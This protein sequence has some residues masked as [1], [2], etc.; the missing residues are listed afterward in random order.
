LRER[1]WTEREEDAKEKNKE[2]TENNQK[3][4]V[5]RRPRKSQ[6]AFLKEEKKATVGLK[7]IQEPLPKREVPKTLSCKKERRFRQ[8]TIPA[9]KIEDGGP[10][11]EDSSPQS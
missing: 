10:W 2:V 3:K 6:E 4:T 7:E 1:T 11:S 8:R 5:H 9:R